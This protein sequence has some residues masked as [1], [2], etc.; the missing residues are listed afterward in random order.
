MNSARHI[1]IGSGLYSTGEPVA[2]AHPDSG[3]VI[4]F[5]AHRHFATAAE[6][7]K[8]D[9]M[10]Y[11]ETLSMDEADGKIIESYSD[12]RFDSLTIY[13]ALA[14]VTSKVGLMA[15]IN[16]T[17]CDPYELAHQYASLDAI[18]GGR[19]G[20]NLVT[21]ADPTTAA[22]FTVGE[23][24]REERYPRASEFV[25]LTKRLWASPRKVCPFTASTST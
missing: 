9:F 6:A 13:S 8:I 15:T 16:T 25:E 5:S 3:D 17:Y 11:G 12:G 7:A 2:W 18:S 22:N 20:C 23:V 24:P 10:F 1:P 21:S 14:A 4:E 19:A